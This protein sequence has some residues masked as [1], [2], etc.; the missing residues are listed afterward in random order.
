VQCR[1]GSKPFKV[2]AVQVVLAFGEL[3]AGPGVLSATEGSAVTVSNA[4]R[5]AA[6]SARS[7]SSSA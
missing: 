5:T 4:A 3:G 7:L 2:R 1:G 6:I